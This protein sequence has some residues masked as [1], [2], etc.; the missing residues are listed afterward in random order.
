MIFDELEDQIVRI[1]RKAN[2]PSF[3]NT[4]DLKKIG[5]SYA[6]QQYMRDSGS[7]GFIQ[8]NKKVIYPIEEFERWAE[9]HSFN[10]NKINNEQ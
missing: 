3:L 7:I 6:K 2:Q 5:I 4:N 9:S 1:I 8:D 10:I